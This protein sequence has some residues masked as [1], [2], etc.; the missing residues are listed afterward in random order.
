MELTGERDGDWYKKERGKK[1]RS[2]LQITPEL[3]VGRKD[4]RH[5]RGG[6]VPQREIIPKI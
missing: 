6:K 2:I 1:L 3:G 5:T 4:G